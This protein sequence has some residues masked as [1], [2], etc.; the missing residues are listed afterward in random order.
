MPQQADTLG[1]CCFPVSSGAKELVSQASSSL[2]VQAEHWVQASSL[3]QLQQA[4]CSIR[5]QQMELAP[6]LQLVS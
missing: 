5:Q 6:E 3:Q 4:V 2:G 1:P